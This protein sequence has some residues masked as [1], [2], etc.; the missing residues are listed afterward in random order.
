[1]Q[2]GQL[3]PRGSEIP[4]PIHVKFGVFD[5]IQRPTT[6]GKYGGSR[7]LGVGWA[8]AWAA[9]RISAREKHFLYPTFPN[10][11]VQASKYQ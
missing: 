7:K 4:E 8:Y 2:A 9:P 11:G 10:V 6:Q 3:R 1:M 5:Y